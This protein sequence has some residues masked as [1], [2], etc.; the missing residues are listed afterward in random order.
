MPASGKQASDVGDV[1]VLGTDDGLVEAEGA[2]ESTGSGCSPDP[3]SQPA[4]AS[5]QPSP[6]GSLIR[7]S[8]ESVTGR[9]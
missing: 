3:P 2:L 1:G 7:H 5:A 4:T 6:K 9:A 8:F